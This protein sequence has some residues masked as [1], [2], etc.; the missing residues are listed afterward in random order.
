MSDIGFAI[1]GCGMIA[2]FHCRA[3]AEIPGA[4]VTALVGRSR[5]SAEKL[6]D[7]M[8]WDTRCFTDIG[9]ALASPSVD[10]VIVC[11]PSGAH[12]EP[13]VAAARVGFS[14]SWSMSG[15]LKLGASRL[16]QAR[17]AAIKTVASS[18]DVPRMIVISGA[19][20]SESQI[21]REPEASRR[22]IR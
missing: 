12:L 4:R 19:P 13:A 14:C 9:A 7:E 10:A 21:D 1:V 17:T 8:G 3:I 20:P 15:L 18:A 6:R 2:R 16:V 11:T 22:W 5:G